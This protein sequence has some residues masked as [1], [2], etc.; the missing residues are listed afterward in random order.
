MKVVIS[1]AE[2]PLGAG[3]GAGPGAAGHQPSPRGRR[4]PRPGRRRGRPGRGGGPAAP[5]PPRPRPRRTPR[6]GERGAST[7][8]RPPGAPT[9]CSARPAAAGVGRVVL[10]S[11]LA[12]LER[13]PAAWAVA[14][15]WRPRP[16]PRRP[17]PAGPPTWPRHRRGR[18]PGRSPCRWSACAWGAWWATRRRVRP[19]TP[20]G[21]TWRTPPRPSPWPSPCPSRAAGSTPATPST[22][23]GGSTTSPAGGRYTRFPLGAAGPAGG[24]GPGLRPPPRLPRQPRGRRPASRAGE[25][26]RARTAPR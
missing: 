14:E 6:R 12:L 5:G 21:C 26:R 8:T 11:A 15:A 10:G 16:G 1:G 7:W 22:T 19:T 25:P 18:S 13:Y 20:A 4:P 2:S 23:A 17:R 3:G 24:A 9:S